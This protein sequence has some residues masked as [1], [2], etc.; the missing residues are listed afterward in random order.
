MLASAVSYDLLLEVLAKGLHRSGLA[1]L[2]E[3]RR[4]RS[5]RHGH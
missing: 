4:T 1:V 5:Q 3:L 2:Q